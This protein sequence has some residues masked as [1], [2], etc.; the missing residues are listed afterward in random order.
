MSTLYSHNIK[1]GNILKIAVLGLGSVGKTTISKGYSGEI[2]D[3]DQISM[4]KGVDITVKR[5][6]YAEI[7]IR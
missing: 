2:S 5:M 1:Q 7:R 3:L 4:T 6:V